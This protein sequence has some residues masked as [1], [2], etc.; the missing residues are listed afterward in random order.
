MKY[1]TPPKIPLC[2]LFMANFWGN[3]K[4]IKSLSGYMAH[5]KD[6]CQWKVSKDI[7]SYHLTKDNFG[8]DNKGQGNEPAL[9]S[10]CS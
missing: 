1:K 3:T 5:L 4:N 9:E 7:I 8:V 10:S 2:P 6:L